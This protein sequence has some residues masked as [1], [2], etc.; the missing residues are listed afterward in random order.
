MN[1]TRRTTLRASGMC[2]SLAVMLA[3]GGCAD[4]PPMQPATADTVLRAQYQASG[5]HGAMTGDESEIITRNYE[6]HIGIT[7]ATRSASGTSNTMSGTANSA[8]GMSTINAATG[9]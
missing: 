8:P 9:R 2:T 3:L 6:R 4:M 1:A 5:E 7:P